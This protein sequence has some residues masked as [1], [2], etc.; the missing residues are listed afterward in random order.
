VI[1]QG[2]AF[3][4]AL[5]A[6]AFAA[7]A[8][9]ATPGFTVPQQLPHGDPNGSP[10]FAGGEPSIAFDPT[11]DGHL[12]V[13]APQGVPA[14]LGSNPQGV[15]Y[16]ASSDHG[17]TFPL[18]GLTGSLT[19]GGDSD[20]VVDGAHTVYVA[21]LE[22]TA[23][24]ICISH[25]FAHS[26]PD[27][28]QGLA[29][30]Q[31]GPE[32]DREWLTVG[33]RPGLLYLTYHDFVGGFPIIERSTDGGQ[34]FTP[35]GSILQPGSEAFTNYSPS[36]GTLV[37]KP[38]L[39]PS[40]GALYVEFSE[41]DRLANPASAPIDHLYMAVAPNGCTGGTTFTDYKI[42]AN[43]SA[44]LAHI[45]QATAR[46][47]GG[48]LYVLAAGNT[49]AAN[50]NRTDLWLFRSTDNGRTWQPPETINP[51]SLPANVLPAIA[52]G[53]ARGEFLAGWFGTS[54]SG[55][56]ND[57]SD[58]WRYYAAESFDGG[59][60]I[61][62]T[63]VS[64]D[65]LHYQDVCTEGVFCGAPGQPSNRNL[66]DFSSAGVD[67][68]SGCGALAI[69]GDP[70]NNNP[71]QAHPTDNFN[72]SAYVSLQT[73]GCLSAALAGRAANQPTTARSGCL[74]RVPPRTRLR[75]KRVAGSRRRIELSGTSSDRGCGPHGR[76]TVVRVLVAV[77]RV[78]NGRCS[79]L[80][81][82]GRFARPRRCAPTHDLRARGTRS[83]AL[84]RSGSFPAGV[85]R[86]WFH[87]VDAAG[88]VE[89]RRSARLV[90]PR[91]AGPR[92]SG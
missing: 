47:A 44:S 82:N 74:D 5:L 42:Y 26:F 68:S 27:C 56:P 57:T 33:N 22:A 64:P 3:V 83:W 17:R 73:S 61:G 86:L 76:G 9:A 58:V 92:F 87:A 37:S 10:Y 19:G 75:S 88:N 45:F 32:D 53:P 48:E 66:F 91:A 69:P 13:T 81:P 50:A 7:P 67:P 31:Q 2:I 35:C 23:S 28:A 11:G 78:T 51:S 70:Y 18:S 43:P 24:A 52:G 90:V 12:Y 89:R 39:D 71:S 85:Y 29:Q 54:V 34:S 30:N 36:S 72:S 38:V 84:S 59:Q 41:P 77:A 15:A 55:N 4:A 62:Y 25:D 16:W 49:T 1:R 80:Q 63:T 46:D 8:G 65:P 20:V 14:A 40:T 6:L 79:F 60:T 21:D